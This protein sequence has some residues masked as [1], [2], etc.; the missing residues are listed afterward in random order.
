MGKSVCCSDERTSIKVCLCEVS[1]LTLLRWAVPSI[2]VTLAFRGEAVGP[3][4]F[5]GQPPS[6]KW[7]A[8]V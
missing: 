1:T 3:Q 2:P 4:E 5:T 7:P 8:S 6:P